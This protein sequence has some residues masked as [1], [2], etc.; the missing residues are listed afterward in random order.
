[1]G[2]HVSTLLN[3]PTGN[4]SHFVHVLDMT[5]GVH[6]RW[7]AENLQTLAADFGANA[8][9]VTGTHDLS[10]EL[11][12]FL[13]KNA[14]GNFGPIESILTST[15]C[16]VMSEGHLTK[17]NKPVYLLPLSTPEESEAAHEMITA[18]LTMIAASIKADRLREFVTGLGA[19]EF[20]LTRA[21]GGIVVCTLRDVNKMLELKPNV[22]GVGLN[23]N[24][25]VERLLP[26]EARRI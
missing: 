8:G 13:Q 6:A 2:F 12:E 14:A 5:G 4:I 3:L 17:T 11:Y 22:S 1:M 23:V 24:A 7:I 19:V 26:P 21:G 18:L 16:L 10:M 20:G 15:T 9:L 25:I